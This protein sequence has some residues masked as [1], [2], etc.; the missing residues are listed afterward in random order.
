MIGCHSAR[1]GPD[2]RRRQRAG[3][4]HGPDTRYACVLLR[5]ADTDLLFPAVLAVLLL[6]NFPVL[7]RPDLALATI[8]SLL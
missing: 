1:A 4:D 7:L 8:A 3:R 6:P 5:P 2:Q